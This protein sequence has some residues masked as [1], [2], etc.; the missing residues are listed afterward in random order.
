MI[1]HDEYV[2]ETYG[3]KPIDSQQHGTWWCQDYFIAN[4]L[5]RFSGVTGGHNVNRNDMMDEENITRSEGDE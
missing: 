1:S 4:R 3:R 5:I 2:R